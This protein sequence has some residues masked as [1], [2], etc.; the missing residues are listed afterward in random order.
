MYDDRFTMLKSELNGLPVDAIDAMPCIVD[1]I[2]TAS[3]LIGTDGHSDK[4]YD[5]LTIAVDY[6]ELVTEIRDR[7]TGQGTTQE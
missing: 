5:L 1:L 4:G 2:K 3:L 6:A 7:M